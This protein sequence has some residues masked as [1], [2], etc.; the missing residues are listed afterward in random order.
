M[1]DTVLR[2][3]HTQHMG[4]HTACTHLSYTLDH[5]DTTYNTKYNITLHIEL[6]SELNVRKLSGHNLPCMFLILG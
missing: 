4:L 2:A 5:L 3:L 1:L 6:D